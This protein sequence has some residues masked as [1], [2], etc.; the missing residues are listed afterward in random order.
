M[1]KSLGGHAKFL[2]C[3]A[4]MNPVLPPRI[5]WLSL[6]VTMVLSGCQSQAAVMITEEERAAISKS[7]EAT[8]ADMMAAAEALN[9]DQI[10]ASYVDR[11][12]VAVNGLIIDDFDRDQFNGTRQW[13]RSLRRFDGSYDHVH[14]EVL[15]RRTAVAT[16]NHHLKWTDTAGTP[17][18]WNSAWTAVFR[19]IDG[20]WKIAYSHE[21][22]PQSPE[23]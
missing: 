12:V 16:M 8:W 17:G 9:P 3:E 7:V 14:L 6:A 1:R 22:T 13:F 15:D 18:E 4:S 21:S 10:R 5:Y 11:P 2:E 19:L 23:S 20:R